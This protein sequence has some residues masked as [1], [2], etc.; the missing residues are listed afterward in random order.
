MFTLDIRGL[1]WIN[2]EKILYTNILL[3]RNKLRVRTSR[4]GNIT[5]KGYVIQRPNMESSIQFHL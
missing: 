5:G 4:R 1:V 3:Y 2:S